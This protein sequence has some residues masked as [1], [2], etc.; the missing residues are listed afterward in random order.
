MRTKNESTNP[1][2]VLGAEISHLQTQI[3][4]LV[5][6][7]T[8]KQKPTPQNHTLTRFEVTAEYKFSLPTLHSLMKKGLPFHK[9][10]KKTLFKRED[11]ETYLS[12]NRKNIS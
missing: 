12:E 11:L 8:D 6:L 5:T 4:N 3:T 7:L 2:E 1:F 10:G 9:V